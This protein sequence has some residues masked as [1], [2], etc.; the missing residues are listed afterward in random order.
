MFSLIYFRVNACLWVSKRYT[1][2]KIIRDVVGD[3][4]KLSMSRCINLWE[5]GCIFHQ[6]PDNG[7]FDYSFFSRTNVDVLKQSCVACYRL[8]I[9]VILT[10]KHRVL[11]HDSKIHTLCK[12][13]MFQFLV[14]LRQLYKKQLSKLSCNL[15]IITRLLVFTYTIHADKGAIA[16]D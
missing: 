2:S 3:H 9:L 8:S 10:T 16:W 13:E 1:W 15:T 5:N 11:L 14:E 7:L 6:F 12:E 4:L